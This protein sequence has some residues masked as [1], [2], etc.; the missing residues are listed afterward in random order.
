MWK[1]FLKFSEIRDLDMG[2]DNSQVWRGNQ[3][4]KRLSGKKHSGISHHRAELPGN[5]R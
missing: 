2:S 3:R 4:P 1:R 5:I